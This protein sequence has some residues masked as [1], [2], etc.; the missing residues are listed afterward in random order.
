MIGFL[1]GYYLGVK[2][3]PEGYGELQAAWA[4][5]TSSDELKDLMLGGISIARDLARQGGAIVAGRLAD[6]EAPLRR[7]A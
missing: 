6:P 2:A 5:I 3:G 7:V 1:L 4:T